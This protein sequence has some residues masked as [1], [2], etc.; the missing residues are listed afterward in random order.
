[1]QILWAKNERCENWWKNEEKDTA[2]GNR[3]L[4]CWDSCSLIRGFQKLGVTSEKV[5]FE[6]F[7]PLCEGGNISMIN[8]KHA[9]VLEMGR[10]HGSAVVCV[11]IHPT[12]LDCLTPCGCVYVLFINPRTSSIPLLHIRFVKSILSVL[13]LYSVS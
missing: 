7:P 9:D 4:K 13:A 2:S 6:I 8:H 11:W 1:M 3:K 12:S 5:Y 10:V